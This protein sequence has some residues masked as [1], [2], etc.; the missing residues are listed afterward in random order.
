MKLHTLSL[1]RAP[2]HPAQY[3]TY[4]IDG[5]PWGIHITGPYP[6]G[7]TYLVSW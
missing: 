7:T 6:D 3:T 4:P 2:L 5:S 1:L